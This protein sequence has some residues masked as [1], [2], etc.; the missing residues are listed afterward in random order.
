MLAV[1]VI[2]DEKVIGAKVLRAKQD[3]TAESPLRNSFSISQGIS[4]YYVGPKSSDFQSSCMME[5]CFTDQIHQ[6]KEAV[7]SQ[8]ILIICSLC[9]DE[10]QVQQQNAFAVLMQSGNR[11][12]DLVKI[13]GKDER[14]ANG[15]LDYFGN[16]NIAFLNNEKQSF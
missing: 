4:K 1:K 9:F 12:L 16:C 15:L 7:D 3:D 6:I 5:V 13:T 11:L 10:N 14:E 8:L 2:A